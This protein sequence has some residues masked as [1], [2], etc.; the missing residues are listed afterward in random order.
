MILLGLRDTL[1]RNITMW[2]E[3]ALPAS[4][5][6]GIHNRPV[7]SPLQSLFLINEGNQLNQ[8]DLRENVPIDKAEVGLGLDRPDQRHKDV[9]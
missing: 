3:S 7:G 2:G 1:L 4:V 8:V 9:R 6:K 5:S